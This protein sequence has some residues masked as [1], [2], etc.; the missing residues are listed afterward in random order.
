MVNNI[1]NLEGTARHHLYLSFLFFLIGFPVIGFAYLILIF[2][3]YWDEFKVEFLDYD[4]YL[5]DCMEA[6]EFDVTPHLAAAR[7]WETLVTGHYSQPGR[8][9]PQELYHQQ[10]AS[11]PSTDYQQGQLLDAFDHPEMFGVWHVAELLQEEWQSLAEHDVEPTAQHTNEDLEIFYAHYNDHRKIDIAE[12]NNKHLL[13]DA[14]YIPYAVFN[15]AA[16]SQK[17]CL[18]PKRSASNDLTQFLWTTPDDFRSP[19]SERRP[20]KK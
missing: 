1:F 11:D 13:K 15:K 19:L 6:F 10:D 14:Y 18:K 17:Y 4:E 8:S 16:A 12:N 9:F 20:V 5:E 2:L 3:F 7:E